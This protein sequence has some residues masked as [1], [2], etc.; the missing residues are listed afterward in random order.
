MVLGE[1]VLA[2]LLT[3]FT[4][5]VG[6]KLAGIELL[7]PIQLIYFSLSTLKFRP[8]YVSSLNNLK[9]SNGYSGILSYDYDRTYSQHSALV[10]IQY[11]TEFLLSTN[12]MIGVFLLTLLWLLIHHLIIKYKEYKL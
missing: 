5:V 2:I 11:E 8:S 4:S 3:I 10:G 1:G 7:I 9:Y 12:I 6:L